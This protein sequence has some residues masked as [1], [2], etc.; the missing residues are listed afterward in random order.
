ML[1]VVHEVAPRAEL[2][3]TV[4]VEVAAHLLF[5]G[6]LG[7]LQLGHPVREEAVLPVRA[8]AV[9]AEAAAELKLALRT[10]A[11]PVETLA[12]DADAHVALNKSI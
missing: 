4:L 7:L 1:G 5:E 10:L 12:I 8:E 9:I 2:A 11:I 6:R 3:V